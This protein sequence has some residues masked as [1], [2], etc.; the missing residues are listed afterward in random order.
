MCSSPCEWRE[1]QHEYQHSPIRAWSTQPIAWAA[2]QRRISSGKTDGCAS[3]GGAQ[4]LRGRAA[5]LA[6]PAARRK[7]E[8]QETDSPPRARDFGRAS[9][10]AHVFP[11]EIRRCVAKRARGACMARKS[12]IARIGILRSHG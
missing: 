2:T 6:R 3:P 7:I 11:D 12:T 5:N 1:R 8:Q 4:R 9:A 10:A